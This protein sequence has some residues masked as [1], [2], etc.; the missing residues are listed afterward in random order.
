MRDA[1]SMF[2]LL[3]EDGGLLWVSRAKKAEIGGRETERETERERKRERDRESERERGR[4]PDGRKLC[5]VVE[6]FDGEFKIAEK[7]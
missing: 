3:T 1:L 6:N 5:C 4:K 7:C 2:S